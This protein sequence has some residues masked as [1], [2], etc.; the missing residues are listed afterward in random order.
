[1]SSSFYLQDSLLAI[2]VDVESISNILICVA[3][4]VMD[5]MQRPTG[6]HLTAG[7]AGGGREE[8]N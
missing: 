5:G 1:M 3:R 6:F 4:M 8:K 2:D 7:R